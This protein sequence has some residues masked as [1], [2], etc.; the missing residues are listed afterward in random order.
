MPW[1]LAGSSEP[2]P[3]PSVPAD[4]MTLE[5]HEEV[6]AALETFGKDGLPADGDER[7]A[8]EQ[9]QREVAEKQR[10]LAELRRETEEKKRRLAE[11][12]R[13]Q[14]EAQQRI[15]ALEAELAQSKKL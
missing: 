3:S 11:L 2:Q 14:S 8:A 1:L 9:A 4:G 6:V 10:L 13:E 7:I 15:A 12:Q 5:A